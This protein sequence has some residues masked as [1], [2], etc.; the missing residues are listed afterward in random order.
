M[1]T[2]RST[3]SFKNGAHRLLLVAYAC[4]PGRGSEESVGWDTAEALARQGFQVTVLTRL[5]EREGCPAPS[6]RPAGMRMVAYD[7]PT[8]WRRLFA[9]MGKLGVEF[10][11]LAW[12]IGA[13]RTVRQL[14]AAEPFTTAQH[15]TY[16][17]YWMPSPLAALDVPWI[18]GPVGGGESI[19]SALRHSL[20]RSGRLFE[21]IRDLMRWAGE[22]SGEVRRAA[23]SSRVALANTRETADRL[24]KL[25]A[26]HVEI[27][28]SAALA[29]AEV[30]RLGAYPAGERSGFL[31]IGRLLDWKGFH[32]GLEA[33]AR[34][35]LSHETYTIVGEGPF[36]TR[37]EA[38]A[39]ALGIADRV[40]FT[41]LLPRQQVFGLL[42]RSRALVHPSLHES[43][44]FVV[45]E[46]MASGTPVL[47][48]D[49]GGPGLFVTGSTGFAVTPTTKERTVSGLAVA[50]QHMV[51][52]RGLMTAMQAD[53]RRHVS[54]NHTMSAKVDR[55]TA[56]HLS[57]SGQVLP[58]SGEPHPHSQA[59][60]PRGAVP[61]S[62]ARPMHRRV[63]S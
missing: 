13:R 5:A 23:R 39:Q 60:P 1:N 43:G 8:T 32:L 62:V 3:I 27:M 15:V 63:L 44:G 48:V 24:Q 12:L 4:S 35:G 47:C 31:S 30:E 21:A 28:N 52:E 38:M 7:L 45:L 18:L 57:L 42:G 53:A 40:L 50:M 58:D 29:D 2:A 34:S 54:Q 61:A 17:R 25:G 36:R 56:L 46:A 37:L 6:E 33:F 49:A 59:A 22:H 14:H 26:R 10:G 11:Y 19:P 20:S 9:R 16:A 51:L 55:L 41:G